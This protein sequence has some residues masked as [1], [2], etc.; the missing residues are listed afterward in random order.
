MCSVRGTRGRRREASTQEHQKGQIL[1]I[2]LNERL[3]LI[4]RP[5][6]VRASIEKLLRRLCFAEPSIF[7]S[8]MAGLPQVMSSCVIPERELRVCANIYAFNYQ[9]RRWRVIQYHIS[10]ARTK[11]NQIS[12]VAIN[13]GAARVRSIKAEQRVSYLVPRRL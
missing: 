4:Q 7:S 1:A 2:K 3:L 13:Y 11:V 12:C 5:C 10:E 8:V 6:K 9:A